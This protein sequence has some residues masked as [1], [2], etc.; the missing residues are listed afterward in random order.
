MPEEWCIS[1]DG[2]PVSRLI[3]SSTEDSKQALGKV[4]FMLTR[5]RNAK[6]WK[7]S[8]KL[9]DIAYFWS[10]LT[11]NQ[12]EQIFGEPSRQFPG[13]PP[14]EVVIDGEAHLVEN[15]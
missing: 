12:I 6:E 7:D 11:E 2:E 8:D 14:W 15:R 4:L 9:A 10:D 13:Y 5:D 1:R 3:D